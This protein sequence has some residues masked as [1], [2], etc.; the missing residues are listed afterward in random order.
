MSKL[1]LIVLLFLLLPADLEAQSGVTHNVETVVNLVNYPTAMAFAPDGRLFFTEKET[2][3][4]RVISVDGVLQEAP[5]IN[6]RSDTLGERGLIGIAI[7]P[8]FEDNG[9]IWVYNTEPDFTETGRY[10]VAQRVVRFE[11]SDGMGSNPVVMLDVPY[12]SEYARHVGGNMHFDKDGYLYVSMGD[13][14]IPAFSDDLSVYPGKI[15]RFAVEGDR[16]VVPDDNPWADNSAFAMGLR[17]P[18]DFAFDPYSD[19]IFAT[20]NGPTCDDEVNLITAGGHYGWR[21][22]YGILPNCDN[23][24]PGE[25]PEHTYPLVYFT[26]TI[27]PVG[28]EVYEGDDIPAFEGLV[29]F[30]SWKDAKMRVLYLDDTRTNVLLMEEV[31]LRGT[32]CHTD[33]AMGPDGALYYASTSGIHRLVAVE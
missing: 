7:D 18:I 16:L 10:Y 33:I 26:P 13:N 12:E 25:N 5:V 3:N 11:E 31:D 27:A 32:R 24:F 29:F 8:N 30:C 19:A 17:N 28:I 4:V 1:L 23:E 20:E 21:E 14:A 15:H 6:F 9:H 2:G 22:D